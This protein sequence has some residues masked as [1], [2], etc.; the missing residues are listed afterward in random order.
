MKWSGSTFWWVLILSIWPGQSAQRWFIGEEG[1]LAGKEAG[2]VKN[3]VAVR[4]RGTVAGLAHTHTD[5]HTAM[6]RTETLKVAEAHLNTSNQLVVGEKLQ[7]KNLHALIFFTNQIYLFLT[8]GDTLLK[9]FLSS[10]HNCCHSFVST[11]RWEPLEICILIHLFLLSLSLL[12]NL[13][14]DNSVVENI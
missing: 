8:P 3:G 2:I 7:S 9:L 12:Q 10:S 11:M 14:G 13:S 5:S 1:R 6:E 4:K